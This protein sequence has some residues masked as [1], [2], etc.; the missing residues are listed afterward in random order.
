MNFFLHNSFKRQKMTE[1]LNF[2]KNVSD[3]VDESTA[4]VTVYE[5]DNDLTYFNKSKSHLCNSLLSK[6]SPLATINKPSNQAGPSQQ[7]SK[8]VYKFDESF[9]RR[10]VP[11][12][13]LPDPF[14]FLS[15]E[16]LLHIFSFLP[17][18]TLNRIAVVNERFCR[19]VQDETLWIRMDLGNKLLRRGA[20]S[21]I[22]CRGFV[23]L[24]LAQAKIQS[25]IFEPDFIT[26]GYVSKLQY[27][28]LSIASIDKTSLAQ[29]LR[30]CRHLKKLSLEAL[31]LDMPVCREIS[32]NKALE[33]LNLAMCEGLTTEAVM[34]MM[35]TLRNLVAL[36]ISWTRLP[37]AAIE[38][39]T[40]NVPPSIM[41]LNVA[42]CRNLLLDK[43]KLWN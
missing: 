5:D 9:V 32:A 20:L 15:E 41:R 37:R 34:L 16:V 10:L 14:Q 3:S 43:R 30:V 27:L 39:L 2:S 25:P 24:R 22:L 7:V 8:P 36:N 13:N 4:S 21:V 33:T 31:P 19:V 40:C 23:I 12:E 6:R 28:D 38:A 29:L 35:L 18:K 17:K 26:E 1:N 42:G 11:K